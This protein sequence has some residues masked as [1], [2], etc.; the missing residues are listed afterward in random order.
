MYAVKVKGYNKQEKI[1]G[2][3]ENVLK[4]NNNE[5]KTRKR[6]LRNVLNHKLL[7]RTYKV[8]LC[9][10]LIKL[11]F[12]KEQLLFISIEIQPYVSSQFI[13]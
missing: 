4:K 9:F 3:H 5:K 6:V 10:Q 1:G 7:H 2:K 11:F 12:I 8:R 13:C